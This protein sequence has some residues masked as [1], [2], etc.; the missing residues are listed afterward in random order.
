[1]RLAENSMDMTLILSERQQ[2]AVD[3]LRTQ[4]F[5]NVPQQMIAFEKGRLQLH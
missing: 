3:Y 2:K 4:G 1:M 5:L